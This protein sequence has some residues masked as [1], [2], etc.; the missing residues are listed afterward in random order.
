MLDQIAA[1]VNADAFLQR[2]GRFVDCGLMVEVGGARYRL[3]ISSG[4]IESVETGRHIMA[5]GVL[6][7]RLC[8]STGIA[9]NLGSRAARI[10][11]ITILPIDTW[12]SPAS[13]GTS[14]APFQSWNLNQVITPATASVIALPISAP[15]LPKLSWV[16]GFNVPRAGGRWA[17]RGHVRQDW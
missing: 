17:G 1:L 9:I 2:K 14:G 10:A 3:T 11:G 8:Q 15:A 5:R 12:W 13:N 4:K 16:T 6:V 7:T